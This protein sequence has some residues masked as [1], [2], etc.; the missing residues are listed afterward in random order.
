MTLQDYAYI[1]TIIGAAC[2]VFI[3]AGT[4]V[5]LSRG[6]KLA[7]QSQI[8]TLQ[9]KQADIVSDFNARFSR[10]WEMRASP[11]VRADPIVFYERFWSLQF[12]QF[13]MWRQGLVPEETFRYWFNNRYDNWVANM[14]LGNLSYQEGFEKTVGTWKTCEFKAFITSLHTNN[15]DIALRAFPAK[16]KMLGIKA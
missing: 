4:L 2:S 14:S 16:P 9:S 15:T 11:D 8:L 10:I 6:Q 3:G 13:E 1:A 7:L 5:L 12:D